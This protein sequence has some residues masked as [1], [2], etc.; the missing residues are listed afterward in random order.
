MICFLSLEHDHPLAGGEA[1]PQNPGKHPWGQPGALHHN[2]EERGFII[3]P[4]S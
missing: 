4:F 1:D 2:L 3:I